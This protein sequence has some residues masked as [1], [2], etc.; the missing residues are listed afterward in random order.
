MGKTV[1][2]AAHLQQQCK[3]VGLG[4]LCGPE[5][6][7]RLPPERVQRLEPTEIRGIE[8]PQVIGFPAGLKPLTSS[9]AP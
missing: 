3:A 6:C 8:G 1:N 4:I 5:L 2:L 9:A 7:A